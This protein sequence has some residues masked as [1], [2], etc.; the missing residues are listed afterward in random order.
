MVGI[1]NKTSSKWCCKMVNDPMVESVQHHQLNFKYKVGR[2]NAWLD[3]Y[4]PSCSALYGVLTW[5]DFPFSRLV[6]V[7]TDQQKSATGTWK[8]HELFL[9]ANLQFP[10]VWLV[11]WLINT[12]KNQYT[13]MF[14]GFFSCSLSESSIKNDPKTNLP[15][16]CWHHEKRRRQ[17]QFAVAPSWK[18]LKVNCHHVPKN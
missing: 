1:K 18:E 15:R 3:T 6:I 8:N 11:I 5:G 14:H 2:Y 16:L 7:Q 10:K 13:L 12:T 17:T 4:H 9:L